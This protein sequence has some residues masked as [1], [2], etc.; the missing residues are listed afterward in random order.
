[1]REAWYSATLIFAERGADDQ[2]GPSAEASIPTMPGSKLIRVTE[3]PEDFR[4]LP[5]HIQ[6]NSGIKL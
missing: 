6:A 2:V 5:Q 4:S 1:M 3:Y